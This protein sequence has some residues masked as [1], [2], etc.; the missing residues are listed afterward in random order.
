MTLPTQTS[1]LPPDRTAPDQGQALLLCCL[2][3]TQASAI[4]GALADAAR[5]VRPVAGLDALRTALEAEPETQAAVLYE[6]AAHALFA[7]QAPGA[8][9]VDP[10]EALARWSAVAS[11]LLALQARNR[12][13]VWLV[14]ARAA[15]LYPDVFAAR[16]GLGTGAA[17]RLTALPR[18]LTDPVLL[19]LARGALQA[20]PEA[21][22]LQA[23][24]RAASLELSNNAPDPDHELS[25]ALGQYTLLRDQLAR[26]QGELSQR[27]DHEAGLG[28]RIAALEAQIAA[29][30][31]DLATAKTAQQAAGKTL[32]GTRTELAEARRALGETETT[33]T[34]ERARGKGL[35]TELEAA[36]A[37]L[38]ELEQKTAQQAQARQAEIDTLRKAT[39]ADKAEIEALRQAGDARQAEIETLRKA[40]KAL[41]GSFEADLARLSAA[42]TAETARRELAEAGLRESTLR[43]QALEAEGGAREAEIARLREDAQQHVAALEAAAAERTAEIEAL[44][45]TRAELE[46]RLG[47]A[48]GWL[49]GILA[50]RSYR[51]MAPLRRLRAAFMRKG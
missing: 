48:E 24:L 35:S 26:L 46:T 15:L 34:E 17:E 29:L 7:G 51:V 19:S 49:Q 40:S 30:G 16:L 10:A 25:T 31:K 50:S 27:L 28:A 39:A 3:G 42:Q 4:A 2:P 11:D 9:P 6:P 12:R 18:P 14:P 33:L 23:R 8:D 43:L 22:G 20:S 13:R 47:D 32:E 38:R 1:P 44:R 45:R 41:R 5:P 36:W 21:R 37:S